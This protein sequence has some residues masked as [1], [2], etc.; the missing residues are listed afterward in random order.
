MKASFS[1][2]DEEKLNPEGK[3]FLE[4]GIR[5]A[6]KQEMWIRTILD[7]YAAEVA[8]LE[9][10]SRDAATAPDVLL[11]AK[12]V[13][14]ALSPS[15]AGNGVNLEL[16]CRMDAAGSWKVVGERSRLERVLYNLV[17]NA[18]RHTPRGGSERT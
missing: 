11:C 15:A 12:E 4:A 13:I 9:R 10:F 6:H 1:L 17:E 14:Q 7:I 8:S 3:K 18:L 5:L 16:S 2:L